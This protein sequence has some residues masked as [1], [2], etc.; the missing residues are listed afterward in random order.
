MTRNHPL[1]FGC[2]L[3]WIVALTPISAHAGAW[4]QKRGEK[5][6]I[7]SI[8]INKATRYFDA[9][10]QKRAQLP[11]IKQELTSYSEYGLYDDVTLGMQLR[12]ARASQET[13]TGKNS[14]SNIGD[15][16]FFV[17]KRVWKNDFSVVSV[18]PSITI[19]SFDSPHTTPKIGAD[20]PAYGL[21]SSYGRSFKLLNKWHYADVTGGYIH[22]VGKPDDQL[23]LDS[24]LG[25]N[26]TEHWQIIPQLFLT[27][28]RHK[29][30]GGNAFTQSAS[31]DYDLAQAQLSVQYNWKDVGGVQLG[32]FNNVHGK[33]TGNSTG[34]LISYIRNFR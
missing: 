31:D 3:S 5:Q 17:R 16:D 21:R 20:H 32:V 9:Q 34:I 1:F 14:A 7:T 23:V 6:L 2:L 24:T 22:R 33:N 12:F 10:G 29:I 26:L 27:K 8:S 4:T 28:N 19:P 18:Q 11:Y 15:S 13:A 25:F 30:K